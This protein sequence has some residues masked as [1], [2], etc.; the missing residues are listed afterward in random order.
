[1]TIYLGENIKRFRKER[2]LTQ[3]ALASFLGVSYQSISKWE[4][5]ESYPDITML[6]A[7]ASFFNVSCDELLGTD[8]FVKENKILQYINEYND[9]RLKDTPY[10]F[11]RISKAVKEFPG[12]FRLIVRYLDLLLMTKSSIDCNS[13]LILDEVKK[14]Y[15]NILRYCA[16]DT[17]RI[18]AKK[19]VCM[20]YNTLSHKTK[21][22]KYTQEMLNIS[23]EMPSIFDSR[24]YITTVINLSDEE[25]YSVCR[26]ALDCEML[27]LI[28]T[29][30]N[31]LF[32]KKHFSLDYQIEAIEKCVK[33]INMFY[34]DGNYGL[35][36]RSMIYA[37]GDLGRLYFE[38]GDIK[39][40]LKYL[41]KCAKEAKKHDNLPLE[42]EHHSL[43]ME[44]SV[45]KKKKY[46]KTMCE[47]MKHHFTKNYPL[48]DEFKASPEFKEILEMLE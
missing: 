6:P 16:D 11:E 9:L 47:R 23:N 42:N 5:S 46:G 39:N 21:N 29:V 15:N 25:H 35:C 32:Y 40:S 26:N 33:I 37:F 22:E 18:W 14:I 28:S 7:I 13:E 27:L 38:K 48:S 1:M 10:V 41:T 3:E 2:D 43:L 17:I 24:E 12:D 8:N 36:Y 44:G 4:R 19:L 31:Q 30:N 45:Y 20:Y 34:D